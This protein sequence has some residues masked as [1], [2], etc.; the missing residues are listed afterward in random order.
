MKIF[1]QLVLLSLMIFI[2]TVFYS[3]YFKTEETKEMVST[4]DNKVLEEAKTNSKSIRTYN[5]CFAFPS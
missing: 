2:G 3:K 1:F 4:I 5:S